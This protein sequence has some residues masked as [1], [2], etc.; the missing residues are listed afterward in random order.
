MRTNKSGRLS[1]CKE[2]RSVYM[3]AWRAANFEKIKE[4]ADA[5]VAS[6]RMRDSAR[7]Y[8]E[9]KPRCPKPKVEREARPRKTP[10]QRAAIKSAWRKANPESVKASK[11]RNRAKRR[12]APGSHTAAEIRLL[13]DRQRGCCAVCRGA[14]PKDYH[15][16]HIVPLSKGGSNDILNIQLLCGHCN[17]KKSAMDPISFM[18]REGFLL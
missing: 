6:G 16:D 8:R 9:S 12:T 10:E 17:R 5:R 7:K 11:N 1:D 2:C 3:A 4:A 14:L 15:E 13:F 18:Q